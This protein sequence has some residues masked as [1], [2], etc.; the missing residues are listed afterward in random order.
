MKVNNSLVQNKEDKKVSFSNFLTNQFVQ[1]KI[2]EVVGKD[3][4]KFMTSILS[5]V[6]NNPTLQECDSMSILNC[7]FLGEGLKLSPSP[8]LGQYY[9]VPF[10]DNKKGCKVAQFQLGYKGYIQLAERS[11]YYK[12]INVLAIKE[13]ELIKYDPLNEEIEVNIIEDEEL[14][15]ETLAVGYYAMFEYMN[16]F[17]KAIYWSKKKMLNHADKYS[18]AFNK[19][20]YFKL[21]A[22]EIP[23]EDMWKYSSY[24]YK[25][26]DG[27]AFKTML[28]QLISKWGIM[29]ID[30]QRAY[31]NDMAAIQ[32]DG[33][34]YYIENDKEE[35]AEDENPI[36]I[37]IDT[38]TKQNENTENIEEKPKRTRKTT[39]V[40]EK[41]EENDIQ[42]SKEKEEAEETRFL[43]DK[44]IENAFFNN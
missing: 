18:Q 23:Q 2:Y 1:K 11:G 12:K 33:Q 36:N 27:M 7:A 3:S 28:R 44:D 9:M 25:D 31:E 29:S 8:Q 4:Q 13:G 17:R 35:Q 37:I 43:I 5:A 40:I 32:D 24:W 39:K 15:E 22:G 20:S 30:M 14:R 38:E 42:K 26:F 10:K 19:E 41:S 21:L 6:T 34:P 16:G